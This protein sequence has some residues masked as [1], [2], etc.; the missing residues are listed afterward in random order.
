[1]PLF[2]STIPDCFDYL[3]A[4]DCETARRE[5]ELC[6]GKHAVGAEL[7]GTEVKPCGQKRLYLL[8]RTL[9]LGQLIRIPALINHLHGDGD[10]VKVQSS[11]DRRFLI[12]HGVVDGAAR[13][14]SHTGNR[15][16]VNHQGLI[17]ALARIVRIAPGESLRIRGE[18][19][20]ATVMRAVDRVSHVNL[21]HVEVVRQTSRKSLFDKTRVCSLGRKG[22]KGA[23]HHAPVV[24]SG[25]DCHNRLD[26][27]VST[28]SRSTTLLA[29]KVALELGESATRADAGEEIGHTNR[30]ANPNILRSK[31]RF[32]SHFLKPLYHS[33]RR[34]QTDSITRGNCFRCQPR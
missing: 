2:S 33:Q 6:A 13:V 28:T 1:M 18:Q 20:L 9:I 10:C 11:R 7:R 19:P 3:S 29:R 14:N 26:E 15:L 32:V 30:S 31:H 27:M 24:D 12:G 5:R 34:I 17:N 16:A 25:A 21:R 23:L 4:R 22:V 8:H